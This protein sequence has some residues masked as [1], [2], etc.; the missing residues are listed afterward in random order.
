MNQTMPKAHFVKV[1]CYHLIFQYFFLMKTKQ[2]YYENY[3]TF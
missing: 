2:P 1:H 3:D